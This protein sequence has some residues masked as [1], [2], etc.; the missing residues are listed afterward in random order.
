MNDHKENGHWTVIEKQKE[1]ASLMQMEWYV[2][3]SEKII[4][5]QTS[6]ETGNSDS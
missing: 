3:P 6:E 1:N 5:K 4:V 2:N